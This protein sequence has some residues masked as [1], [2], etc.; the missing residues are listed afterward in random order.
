MSD[1]THNAVSREIPA[2]AFSGWPMLFFNIL[3]VAVA[4][5]GDQPLWSLPV[6]TSVGA[7]CSR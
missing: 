4:C 2:T 3:L 6:T 5:S 7:S 1:V